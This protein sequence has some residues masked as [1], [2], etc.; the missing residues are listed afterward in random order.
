MAKWNG[1]RLGIEVVGALAGG[2]DPDPAVNIH[3]LTDK[4]GELTLFY[5]R[6]RR[7]E[8][9]HKSEPKNWSE[10]PEPPFTDLVAKAEL[11]DPTLKSIGILLRNTEPSHG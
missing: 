2:L 5:I 6:H 10:I 9:I 1:V 11:S 8:L 3:F 7:A 4:F